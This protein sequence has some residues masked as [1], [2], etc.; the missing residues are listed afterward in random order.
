MQKNVQIIK[1][2]NYDTYFLLITGYRL[3]RFD[4]VRL[5]QFIGLCDSQADFYRLTFGHIPCFRYVLR[6]SKFASCAN[7]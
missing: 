6:V 3:L 5:M 7:Q 2:Y 4:M 1:E